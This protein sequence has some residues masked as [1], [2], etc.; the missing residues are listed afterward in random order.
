[1]D[2]DPATQSNG[3][4]SSLSQ[5]HLLSIIASNTVAQNDNTPGAKITYV[6][7]VIFI[8]VRLS[9]MLQ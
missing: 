2:L 3:L 8:A 6:N 1:L 7:D 9:V 4:Y 5:G